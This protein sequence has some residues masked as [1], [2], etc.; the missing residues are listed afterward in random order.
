MQAH[1]TFCSVEYFHYL[2]LHMGGGKPFSFVCLGLV[3]RQFSSAHQ[4]SLRVLVGHMEMTKWICW[5]LA[6]LK[7]WEA[8][9]K[10]QRDVHNLTCITAG[11][12]FLRSSFSSLSPL[13]RLLPFSSAPK[14]HSEAH[15][16]H[17]KYSAQGR[18]TEVEMRETF[19]GIYDIQLSLTLLVKQ[20]HQLSAE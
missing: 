8:I 14:F 19:M 5:D 20:W 11:A 1:W 13:L 3:K 10:G 4:E 17:E 9:S 15:I 2:N 6:I 7:E 18:R 16:S 12:F